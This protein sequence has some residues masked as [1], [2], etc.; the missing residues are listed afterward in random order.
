MVLAGY[1]GMVSLSQMSVAGLAG[2]MVAIFGS[3]SLGTGFG[4]PWWLVVPVA[5]ADRRPV[6]ARRRAARGPHRR[7]LHDHDHAG[8]RRSRSSYFA[9]QNYALF[10]GHS[11]FAGIAPPVVFGVDWR[12]AGPVLLSR[13]W[14]SRR[15]A[16]RRCSMSRARPSASRCRRSATTPAAC[17]RSATTSRR[18]ASPP[19][20]CSGVI[21]AL[22][23]VLLVWFNGRISPGTIGVDR[24]DRRAGHRRRRRHAATRSGA[25]LGA[26]F[27]V[28]LRD[29]RHRHRRRRAL[30][31][32]DRPPVPGRSSCF[33]P[34]VFSA[35]GRKRAVPS[36]A[37]RRRV[38]DRRDG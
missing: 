12:D 25:F 35:F 20:P 16:T 10:N 21:A 6:L 2:Y 34:T 37:R 1:G 27:F 38:A 31:H 13:A 17:G 22:G 11:G 26:I 8:D 3:N 5:V 18:T 7:H 30:Q 15:P 32:A 28:L 36:V 23:G 4:W 29:L 24:A 14:S 9:Q 19:M 33:R